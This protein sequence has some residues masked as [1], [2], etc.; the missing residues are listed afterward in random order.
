MGRA[1]VL[2]RRGERAEQQRRE[3]RLGHHRAADEDQRDVHRG[4]P[5]RGER[6]PAPPQLRRHEADQPDDQ[7]RDEDP[8]D[9]PGDDPVVRQCPLDAG[10]LVGPGQQDGVG[11]G[12]ERG[13]APGPPRVHE[14]ESF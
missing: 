14:R 1:P 12:P 13:L 5:Q 3:Q 8:E 2:D 4:E 10:E 9:A 11:G 7:R 6:D